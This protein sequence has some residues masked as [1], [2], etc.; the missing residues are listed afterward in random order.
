MENKIWV[1][2]ML[3]ILSLKKQ[4]LFSTIMKKQSYQ[5]L[6]ILSTGSEIYGFCRVNILIQVKVSGLCYIGH[7]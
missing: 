2:M 1:K 6:E 4:N 7:K 5:N 3:S